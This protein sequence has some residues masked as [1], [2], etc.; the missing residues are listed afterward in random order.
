MD[1]SLSVNFEKDI[2]AYAVATNNT[3]YTKN[4]WI[5]KELLDKSLQAKHSDYSLVEIQFEILAHLITANKALRKYMRRKGLFTKAI[6]SLNRNHAPRE[7]IKQALSRLESTNNFITAVKLYTGQL[8]SIGDGIAWWFLNYDRATLRLL[9]EHEY[10]SVPEIGEGLYAEI[11]KCEE[12]YTQ[13]Q[14]FLLNS[15]TNFLRVSDITVFNQSTK[16]YELIEVKAGKLQTPRTIRQKKNLSIIQ[17]SLQKGE[18]SVFPDVVTTKIESNKPL[19]TYV[20][21]LENTMLEAMRNSGSSRIFGEYLSVGVFYLRKITE[22]PKSQSEQI[23]QR[24]ISRCV[25]IGRKE[26]NVRGPFSNI[27][28]TLHFSRMLA[29]Y[30]IFPINNELRFALMTG[31]FLIISLINVSGLARWLRKRGWGVDILTLS[32]KAADLSKS[33]YIPILRVY[34]K[35]SHLAAEIPLDIICGAAMELWMPDSIEIEIQTILSHG[36]SKNMLT[37][38]FPNSGKYAWD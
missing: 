28:H 34:K 10:V 1:E 6:A 7:R 13:G 9:S 35:S 30:T 24:I 17:E 19:L 38:N 27:G 15:I 36:Y 3:F 25:S 21:S 4:K 37:V 12:I 31:D 29:P 18:H 32:D 22:L 11:D 14:P 8:R 20:K 23:L 16:C 2:H 5:L 26:D 33:P